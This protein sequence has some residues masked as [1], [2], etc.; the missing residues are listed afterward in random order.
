ML[1]VS[2]REYKVML[3]HSPFA[4]RKGAAAA[5]CQDLR[6]CCKRLKGIECDGE[7]RKTDK[8]EIAFLDNHVQARSELNRRIAKAAI[9]L[10]ADACDKH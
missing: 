3:D 4:E 1:P 9:V 2:S 6:S 8:R 7:F 5:F 10:N